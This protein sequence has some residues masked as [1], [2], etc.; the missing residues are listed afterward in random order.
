MEYECILKI[1]NVSYIF[2]LNNCSFIYYSNKYL[3]L[4]IEYLLTY[5]YKTSMC[6][7]LLMISYYVITY[8]YT[9]D[10][11]CV[12]LREMAIVLIIILVGFRY[13]HNNSYKYSVY[14]FISQWYEFSTNDQIQIIP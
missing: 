4:T 7:I 1:S 6:V 9:Y 12:T 13:Y 3:N 8:E 2:E 14:N 11:E 5:I 10:L